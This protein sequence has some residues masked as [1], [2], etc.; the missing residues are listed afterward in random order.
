MLEQGEVLA[1]ALGKRFEGVLKAV[2]PAD[3]V[4]T[5]PPPHSRSTGSP[6]GS[7]GTSP[8]PPRASA[9]P[10]APPPAGAVRRE[11]PVEAPVE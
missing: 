2:V 8:W 5:S 6:A 7:G 11:A 10:P 3:P 1:E 4:A 9:F